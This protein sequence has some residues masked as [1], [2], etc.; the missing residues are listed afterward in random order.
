MITTHSRELPTPLL[1][2][3]LLAA[4]DGSV[5]ARVVE[6]ND[7]A[8][9]QSFDVSVLP[10]PGHWAHPDADA[11]HR[12]RLARADRA[13]LVRVLTDLRHEIGEDPKPLPI[14]LASEEVSGQAGRAWFQR[15]REAADEARI[16]LQRAARISLDG[17][18]DTAYLDT[19]VREQL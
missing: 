7:W 4:S 19:F 15:L 10:A 5:G 14:V 17:P 13:S 16:P 12:R 3:P 6:L 1:I 8:R 11:A 2:G 9:A 18:I